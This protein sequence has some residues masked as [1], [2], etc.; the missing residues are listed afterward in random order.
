M[1]FPY[2][3]NCFKYFHLAISFKTMDIIVLLK[4]KVTTNC[5]A[6]GK[7][8]IEKYAALDT[9]VYFYNCKVEINNKL[10]KQIWKMFTLSN[11]L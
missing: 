6:V 1:P 3:S 11:S 8:T 10:Y 2:T 5:L 7:L 4:K 9:K